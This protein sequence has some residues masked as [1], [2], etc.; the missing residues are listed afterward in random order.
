MTETVWLASYPRSGNTMLRTILW[1]GFAM[2]SGA[3]YNEF[4]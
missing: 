4:S 2:K 1:H 3:I